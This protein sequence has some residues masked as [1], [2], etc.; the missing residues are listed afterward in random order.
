MMQTTQNAARFTSW[1]ALTGLL[2]GLVL[3]SG[4]ALGQASTPAP[5]QEVTQ[6][7]VNAVAR[8]LWCPLCSGVRLD[9]CELKA[10]VQ[11]KEM[12]ALKLAEGEDVESIKSYF[13]EQYGPQVLGEPPRE[14]FNWLAWILPVVAVLGGGFF[15]WRMTQRMMQTPARTPQ[16]AASAS[17]PA[18]ADDYERKL[19]EELAKY[20]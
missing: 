4:I 14:G 15:F 16:T 2:L 5:R 8:E 17:T 13:I 20:G 6:D 19:D 7:Q 18:A 12:I 11:M 10:C 1:A 9:S 3:W